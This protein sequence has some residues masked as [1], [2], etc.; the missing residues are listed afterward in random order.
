MIIPNK[1]TKIALI[2]YRLGI[3]GAERVMANLSV[4]FEKQGIEVHNIIVIDEVSYNFSGKL[5][6]LGKLKNKSNDFLNK[7]RRF[8][9]LKNYLKENKFDFIIDFRFRNKPLQE[10]LIAKFLYKSKT[11]YT[12]HSYLIDH[13]MSN[14]SFL[15]RFTH[16]NS[17]K[18]VTITNKTK[19]FIENKHQ[20][21]NVQTIYNPINIEEIN[22]KFKESIEINFEYII[23]V[24]QMETDVKQFDKLIISYSISNLPNQNI[25]LV[26]LGDGIKMKDYLLLAKQNNIED[27]VHFLGFKKNPYPYLRS[28]R[29]FVLSS[30][31]EGMPNVILEAF[32][33]G[34]PVIS[35]DCLSGPSEM[36]INKSN[37]LLVENQNTEK[38]TDAMNLFIDDNELY[39][40]CKENALPSCQHF[41]I[42]WIGQKWMELMQLN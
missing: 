12:V 13:Y 36:I 20:L 10:L 31:N 41:S 22:S 16:S 39:T 26:L 40:F 8:S 42:D 28:A 6:N 19:E 27:K 29:F 17:F 34:T 23:G 3:G 30:L 4:F 24:G 5:I 32:A 37:G 33:C 1:K 21:S 9:F 25:H 18:M 7:F 38:L 11:I 2:G 15:T 35:F 14:W